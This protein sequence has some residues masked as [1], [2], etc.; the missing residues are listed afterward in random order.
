MI[1]V[2]FAEDNNPLYDGSHAQEHFSLKMPLLSAIISLGLSLEAIF[3][4][5]FEAQ[6][7][8]ACRADASLSEPPRSTWFGG[9]QTN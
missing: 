5:F 3:W 9:P 4:P 2:F 6:G 1:I 7:L 8:V